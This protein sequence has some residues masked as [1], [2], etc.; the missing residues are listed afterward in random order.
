MFGNGFEPEKVAFH[1]SWLRHGSDNSCFVCFASMIII[2][3][4]NRCHIETALPIL[5]FQM[6][7]TLVTGAA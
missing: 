4:V 6:S 3:F 2:K 5:A 7:V 1:D